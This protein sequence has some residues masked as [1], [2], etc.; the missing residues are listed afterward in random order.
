MENRRH[1]LTAVLIGAAAGIT[2]IVMML[3]VFSVIIVRA[4]TPLYSAYPAMAVSALCIGAFI[5]GYLSARINKTMGLA[6]GALSAALGAVVLLV[7]SLTAGD[8]GLSPLMLMRLAAMLLS[9]ATGG[10]VGVNKR[11]KRKKN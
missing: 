1:T 10:V 11:R 4:R 2:V 5:G 3:V 7:Y 8:G 6:V 9:G